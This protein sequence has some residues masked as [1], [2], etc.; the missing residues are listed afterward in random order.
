LPREFAGQKAAGG[1]DRQIPLHNR[2]SRRQAGGNAQGDDGRLLEGSPYSKGNAGLNA[3]SS[4]AA[5]R[6]GDEVKSIIYA[7]GESRC[8]SGKP[9]EHHAEKA[10]AATLA[11]ELRTSFGTCCN[12]DVKGSRARF[13]R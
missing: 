1:Q 4:F 6:A 12:V 7:I 5:A 2:C 8:G 13:R 10:S 9:A 11:R 3:P